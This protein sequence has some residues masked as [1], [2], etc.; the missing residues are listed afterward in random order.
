MTASDAGSIWPKPSRL[1]LHELLR[2]VIDRAEEMAATQDR[3]RGL[4]DPLVS[5]SSEVSL[6]ALLH[7]IVEAACQLV[8]ARY[9][10]LGVIDEEGEELAQFVHV[11]I[12]DA[13]VDKI[14]MLPR[15]HGLL[16]RL[17]REPHPLRLDD[18]ADQPAAYGFPA[19]HPAMREFLGVP[20]RVRSEI[21]GNLYL[22]E[23]INGVPFSQDDEDV[24]VALAAAA[25]VAVENARLYDEARRRNAWATAAAELVPRVLAD[26]ESGLE[27]VGAATLQLADAELVLVL[28]ASG[29][30][31]GAVVAAVAGE[32]GDELLGKILAPAAA[33]S[34]LPPTEPRRLGDLFA[35]AVL[36][37]V[38][39]PAIAAA[40]R[41]VMVVPLS[42][43]GEVGIAL[44]IIGRPGVPYTALSLEL[45]GRFA[46]Q[47]AL[48]LGFAAAD[49]DRRRLAVFEDRDRIARDLHDL[50]IQRLFAT[51]LG[52]QGFAGQLPDQASRSRLE[53]Y[54]EDL[55]STIRD[56]RSAIYSLQAAQR[57]DGR[58]RA[59]IE[60]LL[61]DAGDQLGARPHLAVTGP[62]DSALSGEIAADLIA[63]VR[64]A[65]SNVVRHARASAVEIQVE[66]S[67]GAVV[68]RVD[69]DGV[70]IGDRETRRSG[71]ANLAERAGQHA[72]GLQLAASPSGG[73][74]L[75][76]T[77]RL[78]RDG[79]QRSRAQG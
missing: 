37:G 77:A 47:A 53:G 35:D 55:D 59:V 61:D 51:G 42:V 75:T 50:V 26:A 41:R 57:S 8:G 71:L 17:I 38:V 62:L 63:V 31:G 3:L 11:G 14:G 40:P 79:D 73:T 54:V 16:G 21:F 69:D 1:Q 9:G 72:G 58:T 60:C 44:V 48:A 74:R 25:G 28:R 27:L 18:I 39:S 76:W 56:I 64:E 65:L 46:D 45:A 10:A 33:A 12:D 66:V 52:L 70:G 32:G 4:L 34:L 23:K 24:V 6:P 78:S 2:E 49:R 13:T 68:L 30:D 19:H 67:D 43:T 20:V 22:T 7:K 36:T 29:D 5:L 15:G